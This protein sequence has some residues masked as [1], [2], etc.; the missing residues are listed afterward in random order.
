MGGKKKS[1]VGRE[2]F[3]LKGTNTQHSGHMGKKNSN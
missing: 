2:S 3:G 1:G